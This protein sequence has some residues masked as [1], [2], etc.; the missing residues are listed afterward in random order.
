M[1]L[2]ATEVANVPPSAMVLRTVLRAASMNVS[3][4]AFVLALLE[5]TRSNGSSVALA[6]ARGLGCQKARE[7]GTRPVG[8]YIGESRSWPVR[9]LN[10]S[11]APIFERASQP[12]WF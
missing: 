1:T 6:L 2:V 3:E 7:T 5:T 8:R 11:T 12:I 10:A 4:S 9:M